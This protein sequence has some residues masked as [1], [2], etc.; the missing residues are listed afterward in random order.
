MNHCLLEALVQ[1]APQLRYTQ[2]EQTPV[3][4][5]LV[6]FDPLR[7]DDPRPT[8]KV[9]AWRDTATTLEQ[10]VQPGQQVLLEG[11]LM[12]RSVP[13][14]D[15]AGMQK[16]AELILSRLHSYRPRPSA[17]PASAQP[18]VPDSTS[19]LSAEDDIPF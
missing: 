15:G 4:D 18:L 12:M 3:A 13:R 10:R 5:M 14:P 17:I 11:R 7:P 9:T 6:S 2:E 19:D 8:L 1:E 16:H